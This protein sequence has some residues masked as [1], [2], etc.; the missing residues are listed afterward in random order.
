[1]SKRNEE[2]LAGA[3]EC[4]RCWEARRAKERE[5]E[6]QEAGLYAPEPEPEPE[7]ESAE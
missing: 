4:V 3:G 2:C 6:L 1:M 5:E 7:P